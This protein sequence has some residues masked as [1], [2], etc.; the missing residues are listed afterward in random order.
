MTKP[1]WVYRSIQAVA[2]SLGLF[3]ISTAWSQD[4]ATVLATEPSFFDPDGYYFP[5]P[6]LVVSGYKIAWVSL[7]TLEYYFEGE[8]HYGNP[9]FL[10]PSAHLVLT[11]VVDQSQSSYNCPQPIIRRDLL[12]VVCQSTPIGVVSI[13]GTFVDKRGQ[14]WN[15]NDIIAQKTIVADAAVTI[16]QDGNGQESRRVFFTYWEGD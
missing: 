5:A 8:L 2:L 4:R 14:F 1:R 7:T 13:R 11:R 16:A 3:L 10:P 9:R 15:R 12:A 6:D